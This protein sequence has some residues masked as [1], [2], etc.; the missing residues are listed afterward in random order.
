MIIKDLH[1]PNLMQGQMQESAA[2]LYQSKTAGAKEIQREVVSEHRIAVYVNDMIVAHLVCTPSDFAELV[3]GRLMTEQIIRHTD[4]VR[5]LYICEKASRARVFLHDVKRVLH[6]VIEESPTCCSDN[7]V[8]LQADGAEEMKMISTS[9]W[10][11]EQ[12]FLAAAEIR[13]GS[14]IYKKTHGT[15]GGFLIHKGKVIYQCED[16]GR[17]NAIDKAIGHLAIYDIDPAECM[18]YSTGRASADMVRKV[19]RAQI[20]VFLSKAAPTSAAIDMARSYGL[21][22][23][24]NLKTDCFELFSS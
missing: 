6:P 13:N 1:N 21:T 14:Q 16:I 9:E 24:S 2:F 22:L 7:H 12:I 10:D 20:P 5:E 3:I 15:H 4:E 17:H 8:Y 19:I 23:I 18:I 11:P